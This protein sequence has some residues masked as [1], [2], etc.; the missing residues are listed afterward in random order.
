MH[1]SFE[2]KYQ[3]YIVYNTYDLFHQ[4]EQVRNILTETWGMKLRGYRKYFPY[5]VIPIDSYDFLC[6][7][8]IVCHKETNKVVMSVKSLTLN[9]CLQCGFEFPVKTHLLGVNNNQYEKHA[10]AIDQ[11]ILDNQKSEIG[12]STGFTIE[13]DLEKE[14]K[15]LLTNMVFW[16]F[17]HF[18]S[19]Y[20][21]PNIIHGVSI[22]YKLIRFQEAIGF[23]ALKYMQ[24]ELSHIETKK[25]DNV[26]SQI[27]VMSNGAFKSEHIAESNCIKS[28]WDSR[29][30]FIGTS[31]SVDADVAA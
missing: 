19:H 20:N 5:G 7:H 22:R 29:I 17:Y 2:D 12:Y 16:L 8:I 6:H 21:I 18:Y 23:S 14:E 1:K 3:I 13:P 30:E 31:E 25:Y 9:N 4:N 10:K 27:M 28:L 26:E 11:W 15:A 24:E